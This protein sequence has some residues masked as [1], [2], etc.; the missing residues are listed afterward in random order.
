MTLGRVAVLV[1]IALGVMVV[2]VAISILYMVVYGHLIDPGHEKA[3]YQEHVKI[4]APYCS[5]VAGIPLMFLAGW[6][7][8]RFLG[9]GTWGAVGADRLAG[10]RSHRP[11][12]SGRSGVD[13]QDRSPG[14]R[15]TPDQAGGGLLRVR[16]LARGPDT[17]PC[18]TPSD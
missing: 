13:G 15:F 11:G 17:Y 9:R 8:G 14:R 4:A 1:G 12:H 7:G 16:S 10:L 3:Y 18:L 2:N 5:I 6:L